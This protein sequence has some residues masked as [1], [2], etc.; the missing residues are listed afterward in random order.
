MANLFWQYLSDKL[1]ARNA[2]GLK[3]QL[4]TPLS[5]DF[6]SNDYLGLA[7]LPL[8]TVSAASGAGA[9]RLIRGNHASLV[10]LEEFLA[11][12]YHCRESIVFESG[13][14]AN[15]TLFSAL[16]QQGVAI[17]YDELVHASIRDGLAG[18]R[19]KTWAFKH[20]DVAHLE[21]LLAKTDGPVAV[22]TEGLFS[23]DGDFGCIG[24]IASLKKRYDFA[25]IVDEAHASGWRGPNN[26]GQCDF[27][28]VLDGIDIRIHTFGTALG[29]AGGCLA[30]QGDLRDFLVNFGRPLIYSTALSP[31]NCV[32]IRA[33]HERILLADQERSRLQEVLLLFNEKTKGLTGFFGD[34]QS[35]IRFYSISDLTILKEIAQD[36]KSQ[37]IDARLILSPTVPIGKER[38]RICLHAHNSK[39]DIDLLVRNFQKTYISGTN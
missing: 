14:T 19:A 35:P 24:D 25:L 18:T 39:H 9:S 7:A 10:T 21:K 17:I 20:N 27:S 8:K 12:F 1:E 31:A 37:D 23:M 26:L 5:I 6:S 22:V 13:Y 15:L 4:N 32:H 28:G 11:E 16:A 38:I 29:G 34:H 2:S 30:S 3:R 33:L 36:L